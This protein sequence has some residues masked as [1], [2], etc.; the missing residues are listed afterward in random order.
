MENVANW[1]VNEYVGAT[2]IAGNVSFR[3]VD[4]MNLYLCLRKHI[5]YSVR[6][7]LVSNASV[8]CIS[9]VCR[10]CCL[11]SDK[12][13][14]WINNFY[15]IAKDKWNSKTRDCKRTIETNEQKKNKSTRKTSELRRREDILDLS[16]RVY[17]KFYTQG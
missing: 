14:M 7:I 17:W 4:K 16:V 13:K 11:H 10:I 5:K 12:L 6:Y 9:I 2:N 1:K 3:R 15:S 8:H